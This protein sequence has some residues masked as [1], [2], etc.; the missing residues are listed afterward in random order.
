MDGAGRTVHASADVK[1]VMYAGDANNTGDDI[2][3]TSFIQEVPSSP[4]YAAQ[5]VAANE[6]GAPLGDYYGAVPAYASGLSDDALRGLRP[7]IQVLEVSGMTADKTTDTNATL[8]GTGQVKGDVDVFWLGT[9]ADAIGLQMSPDWTLEIKLTADTT[10][11][12]FEGKLSVVG[13]NPD[14]AMQPKVDKLVDQGGS[15]HY[16]VSN[17]ACGQRYYVKVETTKTAAT[18]SDYMLD[19]KVK[20]NKGD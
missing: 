13:Y 7:S 2:S 17:L 19:W 5:I 16:E 1:T 9:K 11:D 6:D 8:I 15:R 10:A 4:A 14:P 20:T 3:E 18:G 12:G